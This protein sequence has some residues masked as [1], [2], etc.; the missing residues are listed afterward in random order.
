[1]VGGAGCYRQ[2]NGGFLREGEIRQGLLMIFWLD[3]YGEGEKIQQ[4][5]ISDWMN[6]GGFDSV[7]AGE[8]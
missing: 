6:D 2:T 3:L 8:I 1:M 5:E 4:L 7:L